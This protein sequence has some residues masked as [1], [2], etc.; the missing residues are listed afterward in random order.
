MP[1]WRSANILQ[2]KHGGKR[3]WQLNAESG[4]FT[5]VKETTLM[6]AEAAPAEAV[7]KDWQELIRPRLN[8]AWLPVEKVFMRSIQLPTSDP[9]EI[10]SMVEL[11][12]EK[13]SPL[14]VTHIVWSTHLIPKP[15][16][17]PDA[18]QTVVVII[19]QRSFVEEYLGA[20]EGIGFLAD[21]LE[22]P[23]LD[24]FLAAK[25]NQDGVWIFPGEDGEPA[26]IAWMQDGVLQNLTLLP[27]LAGPTRAEQLKT[28]IEQIGWAAELEGW[29]TAP[30]V[31][32]LIAGPAEANYWEPALRE[33]SERPVDVRPPAGAAK[34]AALGAQRSGADA[35]SSLL[36]KEF[37]T[38]YRQQFIDGL[39]MRGVI[40]AV[41][42]Y[43]ACVL[44]YFGAL[45]SLRVTLQREQKNL[46]ALQKGYVEAQRDKQEIG[47]LQKRA[48]LQYAALDAWKAVAESMPEQITLNDMYFRS[49]KLELHGTAP[50]EDL[51]AIYAFNDKL[52]KT[53]K[54]GTEQPLFTDVGTPK[55]ATTRDK[56]EWNFTSTTRELEAQ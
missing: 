4:Q 52:R 38:R 45:Y 14:P 26:L 2:A 16:D 48:D 37:S 53:V 9:V 1:A 27:S 5:V 25:V 54:P 11:Q 33:W 35:S 19:A 29:L 18:L 7:A 6:G 21:R 8:V 56:T 47:I 41:G 55:T 50:A 23:A 13:L 43:L 31:V 28:Q 34:L 24:E 17:K 46:A 10:Q 30:P 40:V 36:P 42:V 39:W 22:C 44:M 12:L 20:L 3:L 49:G 51:D 32:H 15:A